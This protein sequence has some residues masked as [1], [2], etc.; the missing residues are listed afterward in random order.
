MKA[1]DL[2]G[3]F[4]YLADAV[5]TAASNIKTSKVRS[6]LTVVIVTLG[7]TCLVGAQTAIDSLAAL[8]ENAFGTDA[9]RISIAPAKAS[10]QSQARG[11]SSTISC[12]EAMLFADAF[13]AG[14]CAV[15]TCLPPL[16][17]LKS[18]GRRLAPQTTVI[19]FD[20]DYFGCNAMEIGQG[21]GFSHLGSECVIGKRVAS[22]I[23]SR[24]SGA[25][26]SQICI[27]GHT[28][29]VAGIIKDRSS[30]LGIITDNTVFIPLCSA[31]GSLIGEHSS[32][33]I[34][35]AVSREMDSGAAVARAEHLMRNIRH[36]APGAESDFEIIEGS[37]AVREIERLGGSLK[38]IALIIGLLTL[39]GAAVALANIMLICVAERTREVGIRRAVGATRGDIR[40]GFLCEALLICEAGCVAGTLLGILC[41]NILS[42]VTHTSFTVPWDWILLAQAISL[43]TGIAACTL[44]ARR[45]A[46]INVV[47]ALRC[48]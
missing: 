8:L 2:K 11:R 14:R 33:S 21:R 39:C 41:G 30:L 28:F 16:T 29:L 6:L 23:C 25:I 26:G 46:R 42:A 5:S 20:G 24:P 48:E 10:R 40:I 47:E 35:I 36:L 38:Y 4:S 3:V 12:V 17:E 13:D 22:Q 27:G 15:Y 45:A 44:P 19:A 34:D 32:F 9:Q 31:S 7:I 18:G 37:A 1:K 43:A